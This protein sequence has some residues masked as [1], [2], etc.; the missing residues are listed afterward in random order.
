MPSEN[1]I[2]TTE[3]L[4]GARTKRPATALEPRPS[5]LNTTCTLFTL[6]ISYRASTRLSRGGQVF[7]G[8]WAN[9]PVRAAARV[10]LAVSAELEF[11]C[12]DLGC[13]LQWRGA[14]QS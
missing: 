12:Q 1:S 4:R 8:T 10:R 14:P 13:G 9:A 6:A 7:D 5:F 3:P 11:Q 2:T